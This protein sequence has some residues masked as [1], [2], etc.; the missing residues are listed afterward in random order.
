MIVGATRRLLNFFWGALLAGRLGCGGGWKTESHVQID[1]AA[2]HREIIPPAVAQFGLVANSLSGA[3][4]LSLLWGVDPDEPDLD[5]R[6][7][8]ADGQRVAVRH[9]DAFALD[10]CGRERDREEQDDQEW[11]EVWHDV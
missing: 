6:H 11:P 10:F 2:R 1:V 3:E 4:R 9:G 5:L 7:P 8:V